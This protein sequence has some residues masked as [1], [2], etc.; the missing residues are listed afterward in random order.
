MLLEFFS[1]HPA[2]F[3]VPGDPTTRGLHFYEEAERLYKAEND[4]VS[5]TNVQGLSIMMLV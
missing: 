3:A 1:D 5:L 2:V 4:R